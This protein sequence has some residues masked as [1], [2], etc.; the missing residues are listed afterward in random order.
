M[1][2]NPQKIALVHDWL[3]VYTGSERVVEQI[4]MCYPQA[5]V[6]SLVEFVP[7]EQRHFL[8]GKQVQTSFIQNLPFARK[9]FRNYLALM[10]LAIEQFDL[11]AYDLVISSS[12]AVAKGVLTGPDQLHLSYVYSPVRYAWDMQ[13]EYLAESNLHKGLKSWVTRAMLHYIRLWD[14]RT[15]NGVD[16]MAT[17]SYF[18]ARR[19][20]KVYRRESRVIRPPVDISR[21][22]FCG[23]KEN[24]Y[25]AA[26]RMVQYKKLD[27]IV[28]AFAGMPDR[29]LVV[30]GDGPELKRIQKMATPNV[31]V[32]GY[33]PTEVMAQY[34]QRAKAFIFAAQEDFG[35]IPLEA[36]ACGTPVIAYNRGG[37][38]ET[39]RG[40]DHPRP[41]GLF[42]N[43]QTVDS[44]QDAVLRFEQVSDQIDLRDCRQ[45]AEQFTAEQ[46]RAD[47][48]AF[49]ED[50]W[51][52]FRS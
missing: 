41:T 50:E 24:F 4:L 11:S 6:Y 5:D 38:T 45:N 8:Q 44:L 22:T 18:I 10:P 3:T 42:F 15:V 26:S 43:E 37:V 28:K 32:L 25:L 30:I 52:K 7:P 2:S 23:E 31:E 49:V 9:K 47:F 46:F 16:A 40:F 33:Q 12:H 36:Q 29:R 19:I 34:M 20:W 21:F 27:L 48:T 13:H 35:I 51:R 14:L 39:V 17:S 1:N